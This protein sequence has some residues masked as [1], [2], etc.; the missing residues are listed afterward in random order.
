MSVASGLS[1]RNKRPWDQID[2]HNVERRGREEKKR[3]E[4]RGRKGGM[5]GGIDL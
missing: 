1:W 3:G 4:E 2:T 5:G